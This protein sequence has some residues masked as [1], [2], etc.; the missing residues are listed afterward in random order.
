MKSDCNLKSFFHYKSK[1][2]SIAVSGFVK[3]AT[4]IYI[5]KK[6]A[7]SLIKFTAQRFRFLLGL[8]KVAAYEN[9]KNFESNI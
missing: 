4:E 8:L 9:E 6:T 1:F 2:L 7:S 3:C 5:K